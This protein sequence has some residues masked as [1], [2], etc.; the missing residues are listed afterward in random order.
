MS[1]SEL[2]NGS[3]QCVPFHGYELLTLQ[4]DGKPHVVMKP[5]VEGIGLAWQR[6]AAKLTEHP[7]FAGS[8]IKMVIE[9]PA[10]PRNALC[11]PLELFPAWLALLNPNKVRPEIRDRLA[12]F[13]KESFD[14]LA[15][16]WCDGVAVNPRAAEP[17]IT[18]YDQLQGFSLAQTRPV[19]EDAAAI[20]SVLGYSGGERN[21]FI[22]KLARRTPNGQA[23][24]D[25]INQIGLIEAPQPEVLLTPTEIGEQVGIGARAVNIL[26]QDLGLQAKVGGQWQ[27]TDVALKRNLCWMLD[28][29]KARSDGTPVQQLKWYAS[30]I[31]V[32]RPEAA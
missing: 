10:G 26:L 29:N 22:L 9:T 17:E 12:L 5:I 4:L 15:A 24:E 28:V 2:T 25:A 27:P 30:V 6:Q 32:L 3:I 13:Q 11:L 1:N 20:A 7:V 18:P 19:I 8:I 23:V 31:G 16:Y 21:L 14:A